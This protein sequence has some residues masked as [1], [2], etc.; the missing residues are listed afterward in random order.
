MARLRLGIA[1]NFYVLRP[2]QN[3]DL[4]SISDFEN[5]GEL[6]TVCIARR[7]LLLFCCLWRWFPLRP[8]TS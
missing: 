2:D 6:R 7:R 4:K 8:N 1:E 3:S 5:P